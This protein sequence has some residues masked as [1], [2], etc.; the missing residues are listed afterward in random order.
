MSTEKVRIR[1][2]NKQRQFLQTLQSRVDTYFKS[3]EIKRTGGFRI[4][5]KTFLMLGFFLAPYFLMIFGVVSVWWGLLLLSIAMGAG[6]AGVGLSVMHD[7]N[8]GSYSNN[9]VLNRVMSFSMNFIGGHYLNWQIQHN[10]LHHTF[11]N[12]EGHDEDIAP[13]GF[14]RFSPHAPYRKIHR[15]QYLYAW[16]F[17]G[18]MTLMWITTKDFQQLSRY[19]KRGLVK[20]AKKSYAMQLFI[21]TASK[22]FYYAWVVVLPLYVMNISW[23]EFLIGFLSMHFT[24]GLIL[25]MVFQPAHVIEETSYPKPDASGNMENDWAVHQLFTTANF[26]PKNWLLS[27]YVGG[28]NYQVEHHL[29]PSVSHIH[30]KKISPI[31]KQTAEEFNYPYISKRTFIG[32]LVSHTRL[33]REF[34]RG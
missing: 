28:L 18:M 3:N 14:L 8:H 13:L 31:V 23:W 19:N 26:A 9:K 21:L 1:Y 22:V 27:W 34:G 17:Y 20:A 10:M 12:I 32:A 33:L 16:F 25:A 15:F 2:A 7:A 11:T 29:F 24:C 4:L 5:M 6:M 30:Y